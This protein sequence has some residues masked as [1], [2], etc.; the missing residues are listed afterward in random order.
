[1]LLAST[2]ARRFAERLNLG[3]EH[4]RD[5][6]LAAF[7]ANALIRQAEDWHD[8]VKLDENAI[9]PG[10]RSPLPVGFPSN[11]PNSAFAA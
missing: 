5:A 9:F 8:L 6:A 11:A 3:V 7:S 10:G 4:E 1:L 2:A